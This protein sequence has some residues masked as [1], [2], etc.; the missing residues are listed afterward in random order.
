MTRPQNTRHHNDTTTKQRK[1][2]T[3]TT[4]KPTKKRR[5]H[6]TP[7]TQHHTTDQPTDTWTTTQQPSNNTAHNTGQGHNRTQHNTQ[8]N[9][10][11]PT[12]PPCTTQGDTAPGT[13]GTANPP[14]PTPTQPHAPTT[15]HNSNREKAKVI[16]HRRPRSDGGA[17][18]LTSAPSGGPI[19]RSIVG[20][21]GSGGKKGLQFVLGCILS[22]VVRHR[23]VHLHRA[24]DIMGLIVMSIQDLARREWKDRRT[25]KKKAIQ[26]DKTQ[27]NG[28]TKKIGFIMIED[29]VLHIKEQRWPQT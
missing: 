17:P 12:T 22:G 5:P 8:Q 21:G 14:T 9:R 27:K 20:Q 1:T 3:E 16:G 19:G 28:K 26:V 18:E 29:L 15:T 7:T 13:P 10:P 25:I 11:H 23:Y 2:K 24:N 6:N 4:T